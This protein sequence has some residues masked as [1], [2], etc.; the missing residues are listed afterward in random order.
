MERVSRP[1]TS[2]C[3]RPAPQTRA[4]AKRT[5]DQ[6]SAFR[7]ESPAAYRRET[8]AEEWIATLGKLDALPTDVLFPGHGAIQRD[9]DYLHAIQGLLRSLVDEVR[10][11]VACGAT[12]EQTQERVTLAAWQ[13]KIAGVDPVRQRAFAAFFVQPAVE[14]AWRQAKG[15][16]DTIDRLE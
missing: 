15:E 11:A 12:L 16:P 1:R 6:L 14:R 8:R 10:A 4:A 5:R 2:S 9:R 3:A 7:C 13:E